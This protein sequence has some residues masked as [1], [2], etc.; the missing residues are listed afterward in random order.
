MR[1]KP[2][3]APALRLA[4]VHHTAGTNAYTPRAGGGDRARDRGL[5]R[6]G[7]RLERH[8]LQL[9]RRPLRHGLRGPRRRHRPER[10][11]RARAGLQLR[12]GRRRA[13]RQLLATHA[14]AGAAGRARRA[15]SP[16]ASTSRTS[17]R[18]R[19]SSTPR[20]A[21]TSSRPGKL[22]TLRAISGHRDTG[23]SECP[24]TGAYALLPALAKRVAATGPAEALL[25][26][27]R[28]RARRAR[29]L[30]GAA[31]VAARRGR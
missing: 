15:C 22:V 29:P 18:S 31:L 4:V 16:G 12:H 1:A 8:R 7:K 5:P 28:R 9:S 6:A 14:A 30:P 24:G 26:D 2:M 27:R 10:D 11:R 13:D 17:T 3:L 21:T 20:A 23:P 25:A 19:R